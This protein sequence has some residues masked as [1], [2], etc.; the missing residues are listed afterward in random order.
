VFCP[1]CLAPTN[2]QTTQQNISTT[3]NVEPNIKP[4]KSVFKKC[5]FGVLIVVM[6]INISA[7]GG[8]DNI[9]TK[10]PEYKIE[11]TTIY[12]RDGKECMGYSVVA[13]DDTLENDLILIYNDIV[14]K[15]D[16]YLHTIWFSGKESDIEQGLPFT[17][18]MMDE[19]E[20]GKIPKI[21]KSELSLEQIT[22]LRE[23]INK[24][25]E[26]SQISSIATVKPT[27]TVTPKPTVKPTVKPIA[28]AKT[29][30]P[31]SQTMGQKNALS[32]AKSYLDYSAFSYKG[33]IEQLE[34]EG[35]SYEDAVYAADNCGANWNEQALKSAKSYLDY[36][37]FSRD[38]LIEQLEYD[39]FTNEQAVYGAQAYD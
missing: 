16:Y 25:I 5:F 14:K 30:I 26:N 29:S 37:A 20:K 13:S 6:F 11:S 28:T 35:Y 18:A 17:L 27:A 2:D 3:P 7:C 15:D 24:K 23:L 36:S 9:E 12:I 8:K 34:Y 39:G 19:T 21:Q 38:G 22:K 31:T 1:K 33:L 10:V 4:K 32:S